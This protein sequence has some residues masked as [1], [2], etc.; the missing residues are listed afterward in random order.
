MP[1]LA[2]P[3]LPQPPLA[4]GLMLV[5]QLRQHRGRRLQLVARLVVLPGVSL[6]LAGGDHGDLVGPRAAVLAL[7]LDALRAGLVVDAPP[8]LAVA[9]PAPELP[10]VG[11]A[12]PVLQHLRRETLAGADQLLDGLDAG[13]VAVGDVLGRPQLS[14][15]DLAPVCGQKDRENHEKQVSNNV[16]VDAKAATIVQQVVKIPISSLLL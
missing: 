12:D 7:Q 5:Q 9:T 13:A 6:A 15:T 2:Q 3:L 8:V 4:L 10:T 1:V 11:A 16:L 14:A